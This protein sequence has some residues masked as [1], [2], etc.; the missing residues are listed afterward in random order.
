VNAEAVTGGAVAPFRLGLERGVL[1]LRQVLRSRKDIY[2]YLST[3]VAF[4]GVAYWRSGG[5]HGDLAQLALAGGVGSTVVMFGLM[6]VPQFLFSDREDGTLLRLRG[7][8]GALAAY[9]TGKTL[10][11]LAVMVASVALLLAGGAALLGVGL[12]SDPGQ[13][14]TM[15]W[16]L[17]LGIAAV[18]PMGAAIG[19][20]LPPAREAIAFATMP[21]MG[22]LF[23]SGA[24]APLRNLPGWLQDLASVF[25]LRWIAQGMRSA[26]LPDSAKALEVSGSWNH[27]ATFAVLAVWAVLGSALAPRLLRRMAR[28]ES[29][30]RLSE[31]EAKRMAKTLY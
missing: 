6:T 23:I 30:S 9:L 31:R 24:F 18:V 25:P 16:V 27:P 8:P 26:L 10:F 22:L 29:G 13:W 19:A 2:T 17:V 28:R 21:I 7:V 20:I 1:E 3:P 4:L 12:P 5:G 15:C 11:V 14:L